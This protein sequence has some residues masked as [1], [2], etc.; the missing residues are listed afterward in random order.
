MNN[1]PG[2][3]NRIYRLVWNEEQG[4]FVAVAENA[5]GRGKRSARVGAALVLGVAAFG[6]AWAG[7]PAP[8]ALPSGGTVVA[9]Q[10]TIAQ[11]GS[12]MTVQQG[13]ARAAIDWTSF[14]IGAQAQVQ[15]AQPDAASVALNRV[16]GADV[17]SIHGQ[18]SANG[19][20]ILVNPNGVV[21]G[22]GSR[23]DVG[24]LVAS[25]LDL[26]LNDFLAGKLNFK[27]GA[28][29]GS[30]V[31]Q[32]SLN[33]APGGYVALLAPQVRNEGVITA[34]LGT[35]ALAA[36]DA[37]TLDVSGTQLLGIKVDPATLDA[38][39]ENRQAIVAE[40]GRVVLSAGAANRLLEQ[41]VAGQGGATTMVAGAD[42]SVRLVAAGGTVQAGSGRIEVQ[43]STVDLSGQ[44]QASGAQAGRID[45]SGDYV[46][47]SGTL[48]ATASAGRG[49]AITVQGDSVVQTAYARVQA[50]GV[51]GGSVRIEGDRTVYSSA[52]ISAQGAQGAGGDIAVTAQSVQLRAAQVDASGATGGGRVRI[53]GGFHGADADL[54]NAQT[55]G[56]NGTTVLRADAKSQ[57]DGGEVVVWSDGK[58]TYA[59]Q[60]SARG[61]AAGGNGGQA[62]VSGKGDLLFAGGADLGAPKG[63]AGRLLLDPRNIIVDETG[64]SV[65]ALQ[66]DDPTPDTTS[67]FGSVA[68]V[69]G[70]GNVVITAPK[71]DTGATADTG[72]VYLF[73]SKTGALLSNLRGSHAGDQVGSAGVQVLANGHYLVL[74][75]EYG[76]V[77]GVNT[78]DPAASSDPGTYALKTNQTVS[79]GA[80]TWQNGSG[81]A[82]AGSLVSSANS[83][84]G[85][86]ANTDTVVRY[87]YSGSTAVNSGVLTITANDRLGDVATYDT[88]GGVAHAGTTQVYTL[89]DGNLAIANAQWFNGRGAVAWMNAATG[90][91][92]GGGSG[93]EVSASV[94]LVGSTG[95]RSRAVVATDAQG[96]QVYVT[97]MNTSL[98]SLKFNN[99][100]VNVR[101]LVPGGAGDAVGSSVTLLPGGGYVVGSPTWSNGGTVYA[102]AVTW[103]GAGGV[104]GAVSGSNSVVG[105]HAFDFVGSGGITKVDSSGANYVI[106]SP[107]WAAD[108]NAAAG[109]FVD[110]APNGA[111]TWVD[112][113]TG[114]AFGESGTGAV[115]SSSNSLV[116]NAGDALGARSNS[117]SSLT[118][119]D[120]NV[121]NPCCTNTTTYAT[122][123]V[124]G[125]SGVISLA[126]GNYLVVDTSW[127]GGAGSVTFFTGATG[128]AGVVSASNSLVGGTANDR[129]G[130]SVVELSGSHYAV[131]SPDWDNTGAVDAGAVT[132]GSGTTGITGT[133][134][135]S[136]SLVGT[137]GYEKVGSGG[138]LA[139]GATGA[140]G[141][142]SD[143]LVLS[144]H[145]GNRG[146][147]ATSTV[148]YG[149]VTWVAGATGQAFGESAAGAAVSSANSLVGS[150]AG[151]Y[152][153]SYHY[154][155]TRALGA[156]DGAAYQLSGAWTAALTNGV[157]VMANGDYIVRSAS[158][159]GG[160]GAVT[161]GAGSSGVAGAVSSTNSLV[162]ST[163]DVY[164]NVVTSGISRNGYSVTDTQIQLTT[165]GDHVGLLGEALT[166]GNYVAISPFWNSG[167]G[168]ITWIGAGQRTGVVGASNSVVGSTSDVFSNAQ[169]TTLVSTGDRLGSLAS[170]T[171]TSVV[172][173]EGTK[174]GNTYTNASVRPL[175]PRSFA[176]T[177]TPTNGV[178]TSPGALT[179]VNAAIVEEWGYVATGFVYNGYPIVKELS[180]GNLLVASPSWHNGGAAQA[181]A[182][183]WI[184]GATGQLSNGHSGGALDATNSLV[185][186]HA[187]DLIGYRLLLEG[188][189][190]LNNG[191]FLLV[192]PQ[193]YDER[194]AVTWGSGTAGVTGTLSAANSLVGEQASGSIGLLAPNVTGN[195]TYI[196]GRGF[197]SDMVLRTSDHLGDRV[198]S[199][200]IT[201]LSDGNAVIA[202]AMWHQDSQA[203]AWDGASTPTSYGAATWI[204]GATGHLIDGSSGGV[205]SAANSLVGSQHGDAVAYN[206]LVDSWNG[207]VHYESSGVTA[208]AGGRYVV[209]SPWWSDGGV[210]QVGAVTFGA[211]GGIAGAVSG[212]N[213]LIGATAGDQVGLSRTY[214][215]PYTWYP[216]HDA[217]VQVV[218]KGGSTN[219]YV[220][221][222]NW[223][224]R[225]DHANGGAGAGAVTW[226][227]GSTGHAYGESSTGAVVSVRNS[228]VGSFAGDGVGSYYQA[229][230]RDVNGT[231]VAT[232]D[233][234]LFSNITYCGLPDVGA[235][236]LLSGLQGAS[237][238]LSWRNSVI[239]FASAAAGLR[240]TAPDDYGHL[241]DIHAT[242]LPTAVGSAEAVAWR[243]FLWAS[244]NADSGLNGSSAMAITLL[245][246]DATQP[247]AVDDVN[248]MNG[249]ANWSGSAYVND[250][251][252][253]NAV[254]GNTANGLL[255]FSALT[256]GDVVITPQAITGLLNTGTDVTLQ[257]SNDITVLRDITTS[258][259]GQ[260]GD[261]T[262]EAG[263]S[264]HL[265]A[266]ITTDNGSLFVYANQRAAAGVVDADCASCTAE[267]VQQ[268]G[269]HVNAGTGSVGFT[270][271]NGD[272]KTYH[273]AG[274][275]RVASIDAAT[276]G[277][278]NQGV[279]LN[280]WGRGIRFQEGA[281]L[282]SSATQQITLYAHGDIGHGGGVGLQNDTRFVGGSNSRLVIAGSVTSEAAEFGFNNGNG[283]GLSMTGGEMIDILT[284]SSGFGTVQF[285]R[286]DQAALTS[287]NNLGFAGV[288]ANADLRVQA[289]TGGM[290]LG[291][292]VQYDE[293][294]HRLT[295]AVRDGEMR[296]GSNAGLVGQGAVIELLAD[297]QNSTVVQNSGAVIHADQ[298][299]LSGSGAADLRDGDNTLGTLAGNIGQAQVTVFSGPLTVGTIAGVDGLTTQTGQF[300][301][302]TD[303]NGDVVLDHAVQ[304]A[305]GDLTIVAARHF[306]NNVG[307]L[308]LDPGSGRYLVYSSN[309]TGTVEGV[310]GYS[311]HYNQ[312]YSGNAPGY[313]TSGNWFLY[314]IAPTLTASVGSGSTIT[315]GQSGAAPGVSLTGFIDGDSEASA[316][317]GSLDTSFSSYTAS[318]AGFIPVGTYTVSL[319]GQG[320]FTN[321]LGYQV[322]VN[323][324][325]SALTVQAKQLHIGGLSANGK[326]YD[327]TT[328]TTVSGTA[329]LQA[330][331][332]TTGDGRAMN[333][334]GV[335]VSGT[336]SGA[337]A[338]RHAGTAKSVTLS[339]LTLSGADAGNY[340][341]STQSVTADITAKTLDVSGLTAAASKV[342]DGNT[343]AVVSGTGSFASQAVGQGTAQDGKAYTVDSVSL[344]GTATGTYNSAH[345]ATASSVAFGGLTLTGSEAG[346]YVLAFG[347]QAATVT[348]KAL[349]A[350][351][352]AAGSK[353]Y[354]ATTA[355]AL[356]GTAALSGNGTTAGDGR[357]V[358]GDSVGLTGTPVG[359]FTNA[360]AGTGRTV[361]VSGLT[362]TGASAG[363]YTLN[364]LSLQ[365]NIDKRTVVV[366]ADDQSKTYGD[367]D[368]T[369]TFGVGGL[370]LV[371]GDTA[372]TVF[373]GA[374]VT[375]TG[376]AATAGTHAINAGTL[377]V[378]NANYQLGAFNSGTLTVA[379]AA[380]TVTADNQ[381]KT[382]GDTDPTLTYT[383]NSA[384]LKYNDTASVVSGVNLSTA[385]GAQATAG[386]HAITGSGGVASNYDVTVQSGTLTVAKAALTVTADDK[387]KTY[388]DNDPALSYTVNTAQLKYS[389]TAAAVSGVNLST[390]T[391]AQATAGTH[392]I[393]GTGTASNYDVTVQSGTLTVAKAALTVTADDQSKTYGD[394]D[395]TLSYT[396]NA[397]QLKYNDTASVVSGVNLSTATGAQAT[398]GTH[399]ITG[400][401]GVASNYDV[402]VQ[403]GTLTVA[404]ASLTVTADDKSKTYG[405]TDPALSYTVNNAQL[406]YS[407]TAAVVSGVNLSTV[408]GAQAT[409]GTHAITGS[410]GVASN[411]DVTVQGG[412]LTVAKAALT[413]TADDQSKTYGD[414]DPALSYTVNTAQLKYSDTAAAVSGVNLSTAIGAQATA[415][416]HAITGSGG[417]ASNYDVTVQSG[418][419]TVAKAALT[420]TADDKSKTY[421]DTDPTLSYTVN[422]A[423]LKYDDTAGVV[424]GVTLSTA[425]G[426]QATAGTHLIDASGGVA[427]NYVV[428]AL[429]GTLSVDKAR[430]D[431]AANHQ[432]KTAG[433]ADPALTWRLADPSQL[434]YGDTAAVVQGLVLSAPTGAG[435]APG[436]YVI[437]ASGGSAGNYA[438]VRADGVLTVAPSPSIKAENLTVQAGG[439]ATGTGTGTGTPAVRASVGVPASSAA[440]PGAPGSLVVVGGG[441]SGGAG[442][443]AA[444]STPGGGLDGSAGASAARSPLIALRP[445]AQVEAPAGQ[446]INVPVGSS[447]QHAPEAE[448]RFSATL[449]DGSPLPAWLSID[450]A[451]GTLS[452]TPPQG[453]PASL[454][455]LVKARSETGGEARTQVN[456]AVQ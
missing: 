388:G 149:A 62:E 113:S 236:T 422:A 251:A 201:L 101:T 319:N 77:T 306:V 330:G 372:A 14:N 443:S 2:A 435:L 390:A 141:L 57:G 218:I 206:P 43:G 242:L 8:G 56:V 47:Q 142:R 296:F 418:T 194:G 26:G 263:R 453:A 158:W 385:T 310:S 371:G 365:A 401:G 208:L 265:N 199:S 36:G 375:Q 204:N 315:Y 357:Y 425:T 308:G 284:R 3:L 333:G 444:S 63:T 302:T 150:H 239:G 399:A 250:N 433:E 429:D 441:L 274:D 68:Q 189:V 293:T 5:R 135:A 280:S 168:A 291:G 95:M 355:A 258:A 87:T 339:G 228:L 71:A 249:H 272:D 427:D 289:G 182:V 181:G 358:A 132:R 185:G 11:Q 413:V 402:T 290:S 53:G 430:L 137:D 283:T 271:L 6:A 172:I 151:D 318:G 28:A 254:G 451:T 428:T 449:A 277:I 312:A 12:Q 231:V 126:N 227:D 406:K 416:T 37:V 268:A 4:A 307:T 366:M 367:A 374:L 408:T 119:R 213:S 162:G 411:Y 342:Y 178:G 27:R 266:N 341:I 320:T 122:R 198:G 180:N 264:V 186:S 143:Y 70:N 440:A 403:G 424:S 121:T 442:S 383:A 72:A 324:G 287:V 59:G 91:L 82:G 111:V 360:N 15:F 240:T 66:L 419:L 159:D 39:V 117:S 138:V 394:N 252:A 349:D 314:S 325:S 202:S 336:A 17:S 327:G 25:S 299:L 7:G 97:G 96:D 297:G 235:V 364:P 31:N 454:Q 452:G 133:V 216:T 75:P 103:S 131:V 270:L 160:K 344:T 237:G 42:G 404:K 421:G 177:Y 79:A 311:K 391:G 445:S 109:K 163:G 233:V 112:G 309:P 407:D 67:G 179:P 345:V 104:A 54:A 153:G 382:Y 410:G 455:V 373:T 176:T 304:N 155:D 241:T 409:A 154:A 196:A 432:S 322:V 303:A 46:A 161:W 128:G 9:G 337:F 171:W 23:V 292:S 225:N 426:A 389:D 195:I 156:W 412:T 331:G 335:S 105:T 102:G 361:N 353:A 439:N 436:D 323:T 224:N 52:G 40:G 386:T 98:P 220:R 193:W 148:A 222:F 267:I 55:V 152:V 157:E 279:D 363:D 136:N 86:T 24:G 167:A 354:D 84:V 164:T 173:S 400:S 212:A 276:I 395:P 415:G 13:S 223:T 246:D 261:L 203:Q 321:S 450:P 94:A 369:L 19:Q 437:H 73:D 183:T 396:A 115:V 127:N 169:H 286:D 16:T 51:S 298:L 300:L 64:T 190:E 338:D 114:H 259:N 285:G 65:A 260:G 328:T 221:S 253:Y 281:T 244:P 139:V 107:Y 116:G 41:A 238:P 134:S 192:N 123:L 34:Q 234:L 146:N 130:S 316:T 348:P 85:S 384:Q 313:A 118:A 356:I 99:S 257:A 210:A 456:L 230:T 262:L 44:L 187:G 22:A 347:S 200:G 61:G 21:F 414:T 30:V 214:Y 248:A 175:G 205:V 282:G 147:S 326:V 215:D 120:S 381:S 275:V 301:R 170:T 76:T 317:S 434:K 379:K 83:L 184:N 197:T 405:D 129:V 219:Y 393:T 368:P 33:A 387:A 165:T 448:V 92:V 229:L 273:D 166:N 81:Q 58:T 191:N 378:S 377:T 351:G 295:L 110:N 10:A 420:V 100:G 1:G 446:S 332:A 269:T 343:A 211:A 447:F 188:A 294:G 431:V 18:L 35:V 245:R 108:N 20:V 207:G 50:D 217:G 352:L 417:V 124:A 90:A 32:G 209:A 370:G 232:G 362:L 392:A 243:P 29:T 60:L 125:Q 397:S 340:V 438:L 305:S 226:V 78:L 346:N 80:I 398:A 140:D 256:G 255:G 48:A 359:T 334:D 174:N 380:L 423:Q 45:V 89:D 376:S 329:S 88:W 145:W 106:A 278:T 38:L 49:G 74:S 69:L 93:A 247:H 144:P 350:S 288:T